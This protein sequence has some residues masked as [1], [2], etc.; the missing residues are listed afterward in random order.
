MIGIC[1]ITILYKTS[2]TDLI[3]V[4][5]LTVYLYLQ[6]KQM[7]YSLDLSNLALALE[8]LGKYS[9][10]T[11]SSLMF[12]YTAELYPTVLR[13]TATGI[14]NTV[15]RIGSCIAPLLLSLGKCID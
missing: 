8:M 15:S 12:A 4:L 6:T 9:I 7:Y 5:S 1:R 11:G 14:S 3:R 13:N 2:F 10:T